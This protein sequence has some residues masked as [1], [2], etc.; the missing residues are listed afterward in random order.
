[1]AATNSSVAAPS[2]VKTDDR[3][4]ASLGFG[5]DVGVILDRNTEVQVPD[6]NHRQLKMIRGNAIVDSKGG[7]NSTV[8]VQVP[9]GTLDVGASRVAITAD[10]MGTVVDVAHGVLKVIDDKKHEAKVHAGEQVRITDGRIRTTSSNAS[11]GEDLAWS[12]DRSS[13][14]PDETSRGL[15]ELKAKKPG[16]SG[17][18]I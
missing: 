4:R 17:H 5:N 16:E 2:Q 7:S 15:G 6:A 11:L 3:T 13:E 1:M 10:S 8:Q 12:E 9:G 14:R 18:D